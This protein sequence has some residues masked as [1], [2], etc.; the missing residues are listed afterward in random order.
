MNGRDF[1]AIAAIVFI[2]GTN[3]VAMKIGLRSFTPFQLGVLR[4]VF[5]A[6]PLLFVV[7]MPKVNWKWI[8]LYGL[9]QGVGQFG[10]LFVSL[11]VGM[12]ASLA[13]VLMQTQM[14]FTALLS[15]LLLAQRPT[16]PLFLGMALAAVGLCSFG[17]NYLIPEANGTGATTVI[18]FILCLGAASM[19][20]ASNIIVRFAQQES[21]DFNVLSFLV[22][23]SVV[24]ILPFTVLSLLAD[25]PA[26]HLQWL[27]ASWES[28]LSVA[29]LGWIATVAAYSMWTGLIKRH[30]ANKVAPFSLGV[31]VIGLSSGVLLLG[32]HISAWQ[33]IGIVFTV[34]ALASVTLGPKLFT[35]RQR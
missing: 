6:L 32:E 8:L 3:F 35:S 28:W 23:C 33:W 18:G 4:Y 10:L 14:F 1:L 25:P 26:T 27:R 2:W 22:W 30:G 13:S 21:P 7:P 15:F 31:P 20:A 34:L 19:W 12:T 16:L 11:K 29:Y 17:M 5:A 24:P 9:F